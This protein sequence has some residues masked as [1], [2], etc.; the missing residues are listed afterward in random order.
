VRTP[1]RLTYTLNLPSAN[2][3]LRFGNS[4]NHSRIKWAV[5]KATTSN[6]RVRAAEAETDWRDWYQLYLETMRSNVVPPRAF[7]FFRALDELLRPQGCARLLLAERRQSGRGELLAGAIFL[8]LGRTVFYAFS[9]SRRAGLPLRPNDLL[10]WT[11]I[12]DARSAGFARVDLGEVVEGHKQLAEFKRK[13]GTTP[14]W[15]HRYYYPA[16]GAQRP[17]SSSD[18]YATALGGAAWRRVP[19]GVTE[20]VGDRLYSFL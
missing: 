3:E 13:W 19:L 12:H 20:R 11:A 10:L 4:R 5:N 2:E 7:R 16:P 15:L 14:T 8:L 1:W 18:G 6:V 17:E 9:G